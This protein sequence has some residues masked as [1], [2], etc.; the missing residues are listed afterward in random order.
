MITDYSFTK[1]NGCIQAVISLLAMGILLLDFE[2]GSSAASELLKLS[3]EL[4]HGYETDICDLLVEL[5]ICGGQ[6]KVS[7]SFLLKAIHTFPSNSKHWMK[8]SEFLYIHDPLFKDVSL[9][10]ECALTISAEH[11]VATYVDV[12]YLNRTAAL[13]TSTHSKSKSL[14]LKAIRTSPS[15]SRNW[16]SLGILIGQLAHI[17]LTETSLSN[18]ESMKYISSVAHHLANSNSDIDLIFWSRLLHADSNMLMY[19]ISNQ[20]NLF[21]EAINEIDFVT[22]NSQ[23]RNL[24]K[25]GFFMLGQCLAIIKDNES[26]LNAFKRSISL[27]DWI[28]PWIELGRL[29]S[30][31]NLNNAAQ[32]CYDYVINSFTKSNW[33]IFAHLETAKNSIRVNEDVRA[34]EAINE[35]LKIDNSNLAARFMQT[36]VMIHKKSP[37]SKIQKNVSMIEQLVSPDI[38]MWLNSQ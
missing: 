16:L 35:V 36:I 30:I 2:L 15:D 21:D 29:Y 9:I 24:K 7:K 28:K 10:G 25:T 20:K 14:I 8:L 19:E 23:N 37:T 31:L 34:E 33:H 11:K 22:T 6:V 27:G 4:K 26:A 1:D 38:L 5:F 13:T 12:S 17:E 3:P 18:I 32:H